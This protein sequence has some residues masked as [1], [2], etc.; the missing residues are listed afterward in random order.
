MLVLGALLSGLAG[1]LFTELREKRSLAYT[2]SALP[3]Q[4]DNAGCFLTYIASSPERE[5]EARE[6][7]TAVLRAVAVAP[8]PEDE[9]DRARRY[10]AGSLQVRQQRASSVAGEVYEAWNFGETETPEEA[11][12]RLRA[13][14]ATQ[15]RGVAERIFEGERAEFV[16]RGTGASARAG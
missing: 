8:L 10:V 12:A 5:D 1:R 2:V 7:M 13:V 3:W 15:V 4:R 9:L 6:A 14:S 11:V 16:L